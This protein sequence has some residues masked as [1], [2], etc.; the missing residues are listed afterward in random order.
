MTLSRLSGLHA[1][2]LILAERTGGLCQPHEK[3]N[4]SEK[5]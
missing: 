5:R 1:I 2:N 3:E 4:F